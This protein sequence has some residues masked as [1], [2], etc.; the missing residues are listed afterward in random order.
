MAETVIDMRSAH[1]VEADGSHTVTVQV[2][3]LRDLRMAQD[4]SDWMHT[5]IR[6]HAHQIGRL[7]KPPDIQ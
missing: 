1:R 3:G 6:E 5:L 7:A 2:S 4:I